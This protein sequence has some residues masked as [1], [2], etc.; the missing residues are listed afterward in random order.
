MRVLKIDLMLMLDS[1]QPGVQSALEESEFEQC[2]AED[3]ERRR[4]NDILT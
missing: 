4:R 3:A 1:S 2:D